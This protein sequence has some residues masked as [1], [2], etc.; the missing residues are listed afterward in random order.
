MKKNVT[1]KLLCGTVSAVLATSIVFQAN[2][3]TVYAAFEEKNGVVTDGLKDKLSQN[4]N[5]VTEY[6]NEDDHQRKTIIWAKGIN[7]PKW[8]VR[9][10]NSKNS[11]PMTEREI[12]HTLTIL[13]LTFPETAD[14]ML[15][16]VPILHS[17][18]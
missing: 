18:T 16:K 7:P 6:V 12:S 10:I 8:A 4:G 15:I 11:F 5:V 2:I 13:R 9:I 17:W 14:M 3:L 1:W